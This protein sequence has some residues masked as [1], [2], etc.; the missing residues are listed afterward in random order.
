LRLKKNIFLPFK[1]KKKKKKPQ[2]LE[3]LKHNQ[4]HY[5]LNESFLIVIL[6]YFLNYQTFLKNK[7]TFN[8][9]STNIDIL[10]FV[11]SKLSVKTLL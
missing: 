4:Y 6:N 1:I 2:S 8:D 9:E 5:H 11:N 3:D 7:N 10:F